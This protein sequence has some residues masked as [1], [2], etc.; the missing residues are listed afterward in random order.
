M[1][2][3]SLSEVH[4][5]K[6]DINGGLNQAAGLVQ[7][8]TAGRGLVTNGDRGSVR[9]ADAVAGDDQGKT[10][11]LDKSQISGKWEKIQKVL[12]AKLGEEVFNSWF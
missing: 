6:V 10:E 5:G 1:A 8:S 3:Q 12:S 4:Q 2:N 9:A 7:V 11:E